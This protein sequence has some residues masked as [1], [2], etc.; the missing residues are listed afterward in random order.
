MS[1]CILF[2]R[3]PRQMAHFPLCPESYDFCIPL[4]KLRLKFVAIN[5]L[6]VRRVELF[7]RHQDRDLPI[8]KIELYHSG[9]IHNYEHTFESAKLLA[10]EIVMRFNGFEPN[11]QQQFQ[12]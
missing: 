1:K 3:I 8:G 7:L 6:K 4:D 9:T 5:D 12:F 11:G 2:N 10:E